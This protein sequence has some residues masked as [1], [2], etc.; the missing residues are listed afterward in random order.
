MKTK[1]SREIFWSWSQVMI[2]EYLLMQISQPLLPNIFPLHKE[3]FFIK[4]QKHVSILSQFRPI[5]P[6]YTP[7]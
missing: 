7:L 1:S 3:Q 4:F 6:F 2:R 5:I